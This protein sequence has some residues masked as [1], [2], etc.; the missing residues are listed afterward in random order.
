MILAVRIRSESLTWPL[1]DG[2]PR[3]RREGQ[4]QLPTRF[5]D[6][7]C[8]DNPAAGSSFFPVPPVTPPALDTSTLRRPRSRPL[9]FAGSSFAHAVAAIRLFPPSAAISPRRPSRPRLSRFVDCGV[10]AVLILPF[11]PRF[12]AAGTAGWRHLLRP[13]G[14]ALLCFPATQDPPSFRSL[15][16]RLAIICPGRTANLL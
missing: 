4:A 8:L 5:R 3:S 10:E 12:L 16:K 9:P 2:D 15:P 6:A 7:T 14:T 13:G 1:V 11:P